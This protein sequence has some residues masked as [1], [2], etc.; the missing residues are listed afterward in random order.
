LRA[1]WHNRYPFELAPEVQMHTTGLT[2]TD[3]NDGF[4]V[5]IHIEAK[6]G[7]ADAVAA[8]SPANPGNRSWD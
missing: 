5:A 4:V 2:W 8:L 3:L 1:I 7:E 6:S